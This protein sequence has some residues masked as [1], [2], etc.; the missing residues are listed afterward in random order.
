MVQLQYYETDLDYIC[1]LMVFIRIWKVGLLT[2]LYKTV[3]PEFDSQHDVTH[4]V[5]SYCC[6]PVSVITSS[7]VAY[8]SVGIATGWT[9]TV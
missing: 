9:A 4:F 5:N 2:K 6:Y 3:D 1:K 8:I 7:R